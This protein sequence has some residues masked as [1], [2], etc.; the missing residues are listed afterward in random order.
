[1]IKELEVSFHLSKLAG[2]EDKE[3]GSLELTNMQAG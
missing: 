3:I 1:M 2:W